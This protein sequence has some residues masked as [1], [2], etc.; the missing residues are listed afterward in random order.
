[1]ALQVV[2]VDDEKHGSESLALMIREFCPDLEIVAMANGVKQAVEMIDLH[3]PEIVF[4]DI[5][6]PDGS[7]FEV[8]ERTKNI[9]YHVI[10]TTAYEQYALKALKIN[11]LDYLLK[12]ISADELMAAVKKVSK[13]EPRFKSEL[14]QLLSRLR[15]PARRDNIT[16]PCQDGF[17]LIETINILRM[18][19]DSNYTHVYTN[20][21]KK[22]TVSRTLKELEN[23]VPPENFLRVHS[24]HLVNLNKVEKYIKG[25]G[26][27]LVLSDATTVPVSRANKSALLQKLNLKF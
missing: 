10:F 18:E 26:G 16:L 19:A 5:E 2:I 6:M 20:D 11:A 3:N 22:L 23:L 7:G 13:N 9:A 12:P 8:I 24:A 1:M 14:E 17:V 27:Y 21:K 4:L 15:E 25:D